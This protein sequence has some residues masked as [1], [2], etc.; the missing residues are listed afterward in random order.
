MSRRPAIRPT[1]LKV[2]LGVLREF[3]ITPTALDTMP[4]GT[5][6]WHFTTPAGNDEDDLD[7]ELAEFGRKNGHDGA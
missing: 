2:T 1:D 6:R 4:N 5:H 3:G 7:R